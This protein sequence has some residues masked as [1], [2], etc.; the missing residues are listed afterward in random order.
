[1]SCAFASINSSQLFTCFCIATIP[2]VLISLAN[3]GAK[4]AAKSDIIGLCPKTKA[5][6]AYDLYDI[7]NAQEINQGK[8][9]VEKLGVTALDDQTLEIKLERAI[10]YFIQLTSLPMYFPLNEKFVKE[11]GNKYGLEAN[12]TLYNGPYV[13]NSWDHGS[14]FSMKKNDQYYDKR[15]VKVNE[16]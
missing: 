4:N 3:G 16:I 13:V 6:F 14:G 2:H 8:L 7:E 5:Q 11:Q 10:P 9:P 1:M 15:N 12:T